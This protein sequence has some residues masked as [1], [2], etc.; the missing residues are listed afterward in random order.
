[1]LSVARAC[2]AK[3]EKST[4]LVVVVVVVVLAYQ[5]QGERAIER[6]VRRGV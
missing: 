3:A 5:P 2:G 1:M 4:I 6:S